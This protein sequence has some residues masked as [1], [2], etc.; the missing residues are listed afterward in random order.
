M[1]APDPSVYPQQILQKE[2]RKIKIR[3]LVAKCPTPEFSAKS[4]GTSADDRVGVAL[5]GGGIRSATFSLGLFQAL[6]KNGLTRK[7]DYLSTVS[8]GGYFGSFLGRLYTRSWVRKRQAEAIKAE[9]VLAKD[10]DMSRID[11]PAALVETILAT[12]SSMSMKFLRD[13]GRYLSP[14]GAG[15]MWLA[16]ATYLRN[17]F[18]LLVVLFISLWTCF[19]FL[20]L[21]RAWLW[22]L[23]WWEQ[24]ERSLASATGEHLW[25]S[26]WMFAALIPSLLLLIPAGWAFWMT[27]KTWSWLPWCSRKNGKA[28]EKGLV[29]QFKWLC[30][31]LHRHVAELTVI[32]VLIGS[33]CAVFFS[34]SSEVGRRIGAGCLAAEAAL[35]LLCYVGCYLWRLGEF[36]EESVDHAYLIR[37]RLTVLTKGAL[38]AT[39]G[40]LVI[41][42]ADSLGQSAYA[43]FVDRAGTDTPTVK[44]LFGVSGIS[45]LVAFATRLKFLLEKLP[46]GKGVQIP[47]DALATLAA[48][49]VILSIFVLLSFCAHAVFWHAHPPCVSAHTS[50]GVRPGILLTRQLNASEST[51]RCCLEP[52]QLGQYVVPRDSQSCQPRSESVAIAFLASLAVSI[53][54]GQTL[55]FFNL[56]SLHSLYTARL[57]RSYLGASN[58]RRR[59]S[60]ARENKDAAPS[61]SKDQGE[62]ISEVVQHDDLQW[63]EYKP[64]KSGGPLHIVNVT[65]NETVSSKS[66]LEYRDRRGLVLAVGPAGLSAGIRDHALWGGPC[67]DHKIAIQPVDLQPGKYH[68]FGVISPEQQTVAEPEQFSCES[69]TLGRWIGISGAAFTTG[70]GYRTSFGKSLLMGLLN[71]RL[72]Y[73]WTS[74]VRPSER[75]RARAQ[76]SP[77]YTHLFEGFLATIFP[78]Q[79]YL[80]SELTARFYGSALAQWYLSDGGHFENTGVYELIR[81]RIPF[82]IASDNGCDPESSFEDVAH[83]VRRLRLDFNA[84]MT[85]LSQSELQDLGV[86]PDMMKLFGLPGDFAPDIRKSQEDKKILPHALMARVCYGADE[87]GDPEAAKRRCSYILFIKPGLNGDEPEDL[88]QYQK[89]HP[90]FPN[91]TT[92]DQYFDEA[93][94]ES[95]RRLG[96]HIGMLLFQRYPVEAN[97]DNAIWQPSDFR[98]P[99]RSCSV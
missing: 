67:D 86:H 74:A 35:A 75:R 19:L 61:S 40:C 6:A 52:A 33:L 64:Y 76:A 2:I 51:G 17:W 47:L 11:N 21:L 28:T 68:A 73:W 81:R 90:D 45:A 34:P 69:P 30:C 57:T 53:L 31:L 87:E 29:S 3:R 43:I 36:K 99:K 79:M 63:H 71:I 80:F 49:V 46:K 22:K 8:G 78:V 25:W 1:N 18:S 98:S 84:E 83:L 41:A 82:I 58:P 20:N 39:L 66:Q 24:L 96:Y 37:N 4:V 44:I 62:R 50:D 14:N 5:S 10:T 55:A 38:M 13:Y 27:Q 7:I 56:S 93:Q 12:N 59:S 89:R 26:P 70:L 60:P 95:Y 88:V 54:F 94:W 85:F 48:G 15:D 9:F 42:F 97:T 91:E 32:L 72:G 16:I 23:A 65:I 77:N 92:A